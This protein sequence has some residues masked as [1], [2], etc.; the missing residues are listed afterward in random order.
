MKPP[1]PAS[2]LFLMACGLPFILLGGCSEYLMR[3]D[4]IAMSA[5][6]AVEANKVTHVNDPWPRAGFDTNPRTIGQRVVDPVHRY[7]NGL[8]PAR[9]N[10][11]GSGGGPAAA[12]TATA[13]A[14]SGGMTN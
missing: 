3:E 5:G 9:S 12:S 6:D 11:G 10:Q 13:S 4:R 2:R 14:S 7:R 1:V 8:P